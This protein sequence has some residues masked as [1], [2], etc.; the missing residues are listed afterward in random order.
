MDDN[1]CP[2]CGHP[3]NADGKCSDA[4]CTCTGAATAPQTAAPQTAAPASMPATPE[5]PAAP[6]A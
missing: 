2:M 1:K 4:T 6:Q 5:Q 3:H